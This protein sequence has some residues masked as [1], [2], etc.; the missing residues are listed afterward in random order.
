MSI[1]LQPEHERLIA[2]ALRSGA[3]QRPEE[4]ILRALELLHRRDAWLAENRTKIDE[5]Y[6]AAQRGELIDSGQV[7]VQMEGKVHSKAKR[8]DS[9]MIFKR[10]SLL[11]PSKNNP[12]F[13]FAARHALTVEVFEQRDGVLAGKSRQFLKF[14]YGQAVVKCFAAPQDRA[15]LAQR[16]LVEDQV[17]RN[18]VQ[19][20]FLQENPQQ[21]F[22]AR[23]VETK[24]FQHL[25]RAGNGQ[26]S[27]FKGSGNLIACRDFLR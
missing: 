8:V 10:I 21:F 7:R 19:D 6:A 11:L 15:K 12:Y 2:E 14:R 9:L 1:T 22:R 17:L 13:A 23:P 18:F 3:Y 4:V 25:P 27:L 16:R 20:I 5:G 26:A 24:V